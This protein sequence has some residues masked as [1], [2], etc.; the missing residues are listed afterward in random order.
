LRRQEHVDDLLV[1][2][3][4]TLAHELQAAIS[5]LNYGLCPKHRR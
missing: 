4:D 1:P 3:I 2:E 5:S